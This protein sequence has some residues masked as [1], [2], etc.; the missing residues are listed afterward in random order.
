MK[1]RMAA[2]VAHLIRIHDGRKTLEL[3]FQRVDI[4]NQRHHNRRPGLQE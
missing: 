1:A 3:R 2:T 4:W